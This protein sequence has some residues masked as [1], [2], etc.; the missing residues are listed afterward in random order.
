MY[1]NYVKIGCELI[2]EWIV[3]CVF[4]L[5]YHETL[6]QGGANMYFKKWYDYHKFDPWRGHDLN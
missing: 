3:E 1:I 5:N 6:D 2:R 4:Q